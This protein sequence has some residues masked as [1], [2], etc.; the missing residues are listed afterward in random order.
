MIPSSAL[1]P[2]TASDDKALKKL[3][4]KH[5]IGL[6]VEEA[7]RICGFLGRD[8]TIVEATIWGIQGSEHCSYKSSRRFLK[9]FPTED[10]LRAAVKGFGS[11]CRYRTLEYYWVFTFEA[12]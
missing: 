1:L 8:P 6:T 9:N 3:L 5:G 4:S 7:R 11:N 2:F 10:E 12:N